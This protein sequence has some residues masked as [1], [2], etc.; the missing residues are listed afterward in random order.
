MQKQR[1]LLRIAIPYVAVLALAAFQATALADVIF[2]NT[3]NE[4]AGSTTTNGTQLGNQV[5][6]AGHPLES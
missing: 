1:Q 2:D 3:P 6:A 4:T 5:T